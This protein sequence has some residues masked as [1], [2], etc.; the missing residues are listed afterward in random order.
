M[1]KSQIC[2]ATWVWGTKTREQAELAAKEVT[3]IGY[4]QFESVKAAM[5][6]YDLNVEEYKAML[7]KYDLK[8]TSFYFHIPAPDQLDTLFDNID[9]EFKFVVDMGCTRVT[10]QGMSGRP[11]VMDEEARQLNLNAMIKFAEKAREYGLQTNVHPHVNTYFM[12]EDEID[13]VMQNSPADL[14]YFAPDTAHIAAAGGDPVAIIKRYAERVNFT[15]LKDYRLGDKICSD[16][17]VDSGVPI[18][19]CFHGLGLGTV[20]FPEIMKILD[21]VNYTG[22]LCIELDRAPISNA[23]SAKKSYDYLCNLVED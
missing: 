15:H 6:A 8:P 14:L 9:A 4:K 10:L 20:D 19:D 5:Y 13:Y 12:F 11:E 22:P 23:D 17:W 21:S 1:K 7:A 2:Y 16:G 3:E 18:M